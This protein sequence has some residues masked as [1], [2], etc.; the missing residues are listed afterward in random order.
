MKKIWEMIFNPWSKWEL[1]E[2]NVR[3]TVTESTILGETRSRPVMWD[4]Y[5][6]TH[7]FSGKV[8]YERMIK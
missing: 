5:K 3:G 7:K 2:S 1:L 4:M 6:R 8:Q